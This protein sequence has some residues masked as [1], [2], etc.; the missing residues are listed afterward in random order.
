MK[1][2][3]LNLKVCDC[4]FYWT[5]IIIAHDFCLSTRS[6]PS[7]SIS[8]T[9]VTSPQ[10]SK[11]FSQFLTQK[12][13]SLISMLRL[14]STPKSLLS[15]HWYPEEFLMRKDSRWDPM[16]CWNQKCA[17][18]L[19]TQSHLMTCSRYLLRY[20]RQKDWKLKLTLQLTLRAFFQTY[21]AEMNLWMS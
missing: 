19:K 12:S 17:R 20:M 8:N 18:I 16:K 14:M 21:R 5:L 13:S 2:L 15:P 1:T 11:T 6:S 3:L 4:L 10:K 7:R 9:P